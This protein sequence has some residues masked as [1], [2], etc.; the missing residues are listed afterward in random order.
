MQRA[1]EAFNGLSKAMAGFGFV[2]TL[3]S[4]MMPDNDPYTALREYTNT[5]TAR[6]ITRFSK[7]KL[8]PEE[9]G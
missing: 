6:D 7:V 4:G 8:D 3:A 9:L 2:P 1:N 5:A